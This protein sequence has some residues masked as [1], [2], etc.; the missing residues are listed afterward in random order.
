[1]GRGIDSN[2]VSG[3]G[4]GSALGRVGPPGGLVGGPGSGGAGHGAELVFGLRERATAFQMAPLSPPEWRGPRGA[5]RPWG[6]TPTPEHGGGG[7]RFSANNTAPDRV[8]FCTRGTGA[9]AGAC[10]PS[11]AGAPRKGS[12]LRGV[13]DAA[14]APEGSPPFSTGPRSFCFRTDGWGDDK[15][16]IADLRVGGLVGTGVRRGGRRLQ[17]GGPHPGDRTPPTIFG[18]SSKYPA[19][20][21]FAGGAGGLGP[22]LVPPARRTGT[23]VEFKGASARFRGDESGD[24]GTG[25]KRD[26]ES[27]SDSAGGGGTN[28]QRGSGG[29]RVATRGSLRPKG[30]AGGRRWGGDGRAGRWAPDLQ[31]GHI[32]SREEEKKKN[33]PPTKF[34]AWRSPTTAR[35]RLSKRVMGVPRPARGGP[36]GGRRGPRPKEKGRPRRDARGPRGR[37]PGGG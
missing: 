29:G 5:L 30:E 37:G 15:G 34:P 7:F 6:G 20:F 3:G 24:S 31:T 19:N 18:C 32:T 25:K 36:G 2:H 26:G 23:R 17:L 11:A 14:R 9:G 12:I 33:G 4:G 8:A 35:F 21:H 10:P 22:L 27:A 28:R 1:V 13:G 16:S